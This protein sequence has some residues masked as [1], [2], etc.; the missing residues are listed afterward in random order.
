MG[1]CTLN[2]YSR[3]IIP[4]CPDFWFSISFQETNRPHHK[5]RWILQDF[6][7]VDQLRPH[8][9]CQGMVDTSYHF[10]LDTAAIPVVN[11]RL[12]RFCQYFLLKSKGWV[13]IR[14]ANCPQLAHRIQ[15]E[16]E[17]ND[18]SWNLP[19][20]QNLKPQSNKGYGGTPGQWWQWWGWQW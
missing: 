18:A 15:T 7:G 2:L 6:V 1:C 4:D 14:Q 9:H 17:V 19:V 12:A 5:P 3:N 11:L 10:K 8:H 20:F 13:K 16:V